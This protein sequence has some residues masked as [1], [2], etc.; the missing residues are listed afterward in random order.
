MADYV[1]ELEVAVDETFDRNEFDAL[2]DSLADQVVELRNGIDGDVSANTKERIITI[3]LTLTDDTDEGAFTRGLAAARA[4][5]HAT[6]GSTP[7]W[8][9]VTL[10]HSPQELTAV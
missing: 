7:G 3:H 2:F 6:G 8:E 10:S 5:I 4:A 9:K 1:V